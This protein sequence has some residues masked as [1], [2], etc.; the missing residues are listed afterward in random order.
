MSKV[1]ITVAQIQ[2]HLKNGKTRD[3]IKEMYNLKAKDI[4]A[5]FQHPDLKGRKTVK[6]YEPGFEFVSETAVAESLTRIPSN[7]EEEVYAENS[8]EQD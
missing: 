2:G 6:P 1:Q 8:M 7:P 3:D 5:M 4:K